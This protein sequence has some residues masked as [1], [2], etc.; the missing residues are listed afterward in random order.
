MDYSLPGSSVHRIL[1]ARILERVVIPFSMGSSQPRD[2]TRVSWIAG[3]FFTV[4][5][6]I[7][8][9]EYLGVYPIFLQ[10]I[11]LVQKSNRDLLP[12]RRIF[13]QLSYQGSAEKDP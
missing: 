8:T 13:Y 1:Q 2:Q 6:T 9:Q 4:W 10:G 5:V 3:G 11:F 7:E 12:C